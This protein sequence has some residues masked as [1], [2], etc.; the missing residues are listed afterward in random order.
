[1]LPS[2]IITLAWNSLYSHTALS[3]HVVWL[4]RLKFLQIFIAQI[5]LKIKSNYSRAS[6][7][8][9]R[10]CCNL[11]MVTFVSDYLGTKFKSNCG[12]RKKN[13]PLLAF[14]L[15]SR[16]R[17][18]LVCW[19]L[20]HLPEVTGGPITKP[21][22]RPCPRLAPLI[23]VLQHSFVGWQSQKKKTVD[24]LYPFAC[25]IKLCFSIVHKKRTNIGLVRCSLWAISDLQP[26]LLVRSDRCPMAGVWSP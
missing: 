19:N 8:D 26:P 14:T 9:G 1:M 23:A 4:R 25:F 7:N 17:D 12:G 13:N 21:H 3:F 11:F 2:S 20:G 16:R 5:N 22:E 15:V 18:A 10:V 6:I 24:G